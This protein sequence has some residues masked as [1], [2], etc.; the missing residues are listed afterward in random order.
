MTDM[1]FSDAKM[2]KP[3]VDGQ[4]RIVRYGPTKNVPGRQTG[5]GKNKCV[6]G[7]TR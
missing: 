4:S 6:T 3:V 1:S 2:A 5:S 7:R